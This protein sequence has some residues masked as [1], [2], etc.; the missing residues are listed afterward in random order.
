MLKTINQ[1]FLFFIIYSSS[2]QVNLE[3]ELNIHK[4]H[5]GT[6]NDVIINEELNEIISADSYGN[7]L[8]HL[9]SFHLLSQILI[10]IDSCSK[11][12]HLIQFL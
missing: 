2:A 5:K 11:L 6:V 9:Y 3:F 4:Y 8:V 10:S 1:F 12:N 7:I